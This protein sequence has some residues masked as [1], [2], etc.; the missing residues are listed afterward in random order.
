MLI[1]KMHSAV[2]TQSHST[3]ASISKHQKNDDF[4]LLDRKQISKI[5]KRL[6]LRTK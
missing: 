3:L 1:D 2:N 5:N 4:L 6:Y